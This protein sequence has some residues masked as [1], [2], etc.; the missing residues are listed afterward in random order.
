MI[1]RTIFLAVALLFAT[2]APTLSAANNPTSTVNVDGSALIEVEPNEF[3]LLITLDEGDTKGRIPLAE[4]QHKLLNALKAIGVDCTK[5]LKS[6][7]MNS[8]WNRRRT[9]LSSLQ[10]LLTLPSAD[11]LYR[12]YEAL[13]PLGVSNVELQNVTHTD[14]KSFESQARRKAIQDAKAKAI[15]LATAIGQNIG[16]CC[17]INDYGANTELP[18]RKSAPMLMRANADMH[19]HQTSLE[20]TSFNS[21]KLRYR[22]A[23]QFILTEK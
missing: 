19:S 22:V 5:Q 23:A 9:S 18:I 16:A 3:T 2:A 21:I 4:Q 15:E 6:Y 17:S 10:L 11:M 20:T 7:D 14:L 1:I 8:D 13:M 12:T